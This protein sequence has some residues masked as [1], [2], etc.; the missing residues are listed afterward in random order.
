[1]LN[2][3]DEGCPC[4]NAGL[5]FDEF[6][7]A[8]KIMMQS[9]NK[10]EA[11]TH[12]ADFNDGGHWGIFF[13][14]SLPFALIGL[15]AAYRNIKGSWSNRKKLAE[16][17]SAIGKDLERAKDS[18]SSA[19]ETQKPEYEK[20]INNLTAFQNTLKYSKFDANFNLIVPG[21]INGA[22]SSMVFASGAWH[23]PFALPLIA[24]YALGQTGRN[25]FDFARVA[26][27]HICIE[28][29]VESQQTPTDE[30]VQTGVDKLNQIAHSQRLF[31]GANAASFAIFTAGALLTF[32]SIP[33]LAVGV[34]A[35]GLP[36]GLAMLG[37]G[38]LS[39]G[40]M[41]NIWPRKFKPRNG[42]LGVN[43]DRKKMTLQS[44]VEQIGIRRQQKRA[45]KDAFKTVALPCRKNRFWRSW[46]RFWYSALTA[47][48]FGANRGERAL[49]RNNRIVFDDNKV[50]ILGNVPALLS[51]IHRMQ[52]IR[53]ESSSDLPIDLKDQLPLLND[54]G[55]LDNVLNLWLSEFREGSSPEACGE[56]ACSH[57]THEHADEPHMPDN[58][59]APKACS[60]GVGHPETLWDRIRPIQ[61]FSRPESSEFTH[62]STVHL[63]PEKCSELTESD[64]KTLKDAIAFYMQFSF[65]E[66]LRYEQY[67]LNN[68]FWQLR[69]AEKAAAK[70]AVT[71]QRQRRIRRNQVGIA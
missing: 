8:I 29:V 10:E 70:N 69:K 17:V 40:I 23:Q 12:L 18:A 59:F 26:N 65:E 6:A 33:A 20:L 54:L 45:I 61:I 36:V 9:D 49:H 41:N 28:D 14:V 64:Q 19:D 39:T 47:M 63:H 46:K 11:L 66:K 53:T 34:G 30:P 51:K 38:A 55:I 3:E 27:R 4:C 57:G 42:D 44:C 5:D 35:A 52:Q 71:E 31:Y 22:A 60:N 62:E 21:I 15:T 1:M 24:A 7:A 32:V 67:G 25:I 68:F 50:R 13:G 16:L 56:G 43:A 48:P 37:Y 2:P 58:D